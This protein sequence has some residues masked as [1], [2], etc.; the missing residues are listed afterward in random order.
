M[1]RLYHC[2]ACNLKFW[3]EAKRYGNPCPKC[4][5]TQR[6]KFIGVLHVEYGGQTPCTEACRKSTARKCRCS[7]RG[8]RHGE[9]VWEM[10]AVEDR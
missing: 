6:I 9:D 1:K 8:V 2:G 10:S 4:V 7:C 5:S 3:A